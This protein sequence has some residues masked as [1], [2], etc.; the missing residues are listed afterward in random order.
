MIDIDRALLSRLARGAEA[1]FAG[2]GIEVGVDCGQGAQEEAADVGE[3]G[4]AAGR[5]A[6]LSEEGVEGAERIVDAGG[7][8]EAAGSG[9]EW[10]QEVFGFVGLRGR[11]AWA[12]RG[13]RVD[14]RQTALTTGGR[15][16]LAA[17]G[18]EVGTERVECPFL[19]FHFW[20]EI[21]RRIPTP[22]FWQ[23]RLQDI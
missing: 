4:G 14:D 17:S 5:D 23:K 20:V 6:S 15:A 13:I 12:E 7:V 10:G 9:G 2:V 8:L 22:C 18:S 11:V 3:G 1:G 19:S 16:V 21:G